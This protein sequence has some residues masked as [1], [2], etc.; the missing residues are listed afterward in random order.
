[1]LI[2]HRKGVISHTASCIPLNLTLLTLGVCCWETEGESTYNCY[3]KLVKELFGSKPNLCKVTFSLTL[4]IMDSWK[5]AQ[6][7]IKEWSWHSWYSKTLRLVWLQFWSKFKG[8]HR[9][10]WHSWTTGKEPTLGPDDPVPTYGETQSHGLRAHSLLTTKE[11][12]LPQVSPTSTSHH[13][14]I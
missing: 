9:L 11:L 12:D 3:V 8:K 10:Q 14:N 7:F 4:Q 5:S 6:V 13:R 2:N 1:M